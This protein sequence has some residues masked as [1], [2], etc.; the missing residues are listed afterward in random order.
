MPPAFMANELRLLTL[1]KDAPSA[2]K[3]KLQHAAIAPMIIR[4]VPITHPVSASTKG[5]ESTPDPMAEA[6]NENILPLKL[7]LFNFPK[8][9]LK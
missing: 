2:I 8:A 6:H 4:I 9:L 7:P 5:N 3:I 1:A